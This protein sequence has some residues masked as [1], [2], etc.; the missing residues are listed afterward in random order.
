MIHMVS[1]SATAA[2]FSDFDILAVEEEIWVIKTA[3]Q[4]TSPKK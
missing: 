3:C 1:V 2:G 4:V